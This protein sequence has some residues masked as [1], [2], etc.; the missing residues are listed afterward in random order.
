MRVLLLLCYLVDISHYFFAFFC[1]LW[2]S[3]DMWMENKAKAVEKA[4]FHL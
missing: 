1:S 4:S 2:R 3:A